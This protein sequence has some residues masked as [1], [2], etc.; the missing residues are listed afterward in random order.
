MLRAGCPLH[1]WFPLKP[2]TYRQCLWRHLW[3][4]GAPRT[5]LNGKRGQTRQHTLHCERSGVQCLTL[6]RSVKPTGYSEK[7][8]DLCPNTDAADAQ[9]CT[10]PGAPTSQL[11]RLRIIARFWH[12]S[13]PT[14]YHSG[15]NQWKSRSKSRRNISL[16][17][18][19]VVGK[20]NCFHSAL[21]TRELWS[22]Q[23]K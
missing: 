23:S 4:G 12:A 14:S 2:Y 3:S 20:Y 15:P 19:G 21:N 1:Y 9:P 10:P 22:K 18:R 6:S 5:S 8:R 17:H 11:T 7:N 16:R 13:L